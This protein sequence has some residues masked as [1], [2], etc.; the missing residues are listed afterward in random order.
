MGKVRTCYMS[1]PPKKPRKYSKTVWS[2]KKQ[3]F[4]YKQATAIEK[5]IETYHFKV[6][7]EQRVTHW[8]ASVSKDL[9]WAIGQRWINRCLIYDTYKV[10]GQRYRFIMSKEYE[11]ITIY[12]IDKELENKDNKYHKRVRISDE[13]RLRIKQHFQLLF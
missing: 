4:K 5:A 12:K 3:I 2:E 11:L 13:E 1:W 10:Y 6:R 9:A 7:F 8:K